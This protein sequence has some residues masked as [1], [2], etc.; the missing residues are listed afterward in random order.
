MI[1]ND[2]IAN[3][4][5]FSQLSHPPSIFLF[6]F[7]PTLLFLHP[8]SVL[9]R[10]SIFPPLRAVVHIQVDDV[11]EFCPVFR[12][13]LYKAS[14]TEGKIYDSILQVFKCYILL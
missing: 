5:S 14:V 6:L 12:E 9:P 10:R 1:S 7:I 4:F 3:A 8:P 11:N 13:P 2:F